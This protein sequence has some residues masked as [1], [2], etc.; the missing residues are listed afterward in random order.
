MNVRS[1]KFLNILTVLLSMSLQTVTQIL[2]GDLSLTIRSFAGKRRGQNFCPIFFW[3]YLLLLM[4][5]LA[6]WGT[7]RPRLFASVN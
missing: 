4:T 6:P 1:N 3:V 5:P 2:S 7:G